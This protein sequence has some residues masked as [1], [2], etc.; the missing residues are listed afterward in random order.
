VA[1]EAALAQLNGWDFDVFALHAASAGRPLVPL[2]MALFQRHGLLARFGIDAELLARVVGTMQAGYGPAPYHNRLHAA[3]VTQTFY[4]LMRC[5]AVARHASDVCR[6]CRTRG[7]ARRCAERYAT[8]R[9]ASLHSAALFS[10]RRGVALPSSARSLCL[11]ARAMS[12][13]ARLHRRGRV[14][15]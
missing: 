15:A 9:D 3:D 6:R 13:S 12:C 5:D 14:I 11:A 10:A 7:A 8:R 4:A 1:L 2:A